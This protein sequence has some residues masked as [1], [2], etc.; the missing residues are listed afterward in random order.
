MIVRDEVAAL[1]RCLDALWCALDDV[2]F[3]DTGSTDGTA[4]WLRA[5]TGV[6]PERVA[7]DPRIDRFDVVRNHN[8]A[9]LRTD[10]VLHLDADEV[11]TPGDLARLIDAAGAADGAMLPWITTTPEGRF[12][13]YKCPLVRRGVPHVGRVHEN[14]QQGLRAR[15]MRAVYVAEA[16]LDHLPDPTRAGAKQRRYRE[17]LGRAVAEDPSDA[18]SWWFLG[19][20]ARAV[21]AVDDAATAFERAAAGDARRFPVEVASAALARAELGGDAGRWRAAALDVW[22]A[23]RDDFEWAARPDVAALPEASFAALGR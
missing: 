11:L 18:R 23:T 20:D 12:D 15:G 17:A 13:D 22:R 5:K 1:P 6:E 2:A 19:E 3:T 7:F 4:E 14:L 21:G 8:A 10:W 16:R 9:R